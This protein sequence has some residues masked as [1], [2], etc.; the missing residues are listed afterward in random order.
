MSEAY[1]AYKQFE[2]RL[3][4]IIH[5]GEDKDGPDGSDGPGDQLR[6]GADILWWAMTDEERAQCNNEVALMI[7]E[8]EKVPNAE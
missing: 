7:S 3:Q 6:D 4:A 5:A 8:S 2:V 1:Q